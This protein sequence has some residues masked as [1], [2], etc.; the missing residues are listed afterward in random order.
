VIYGPGRQA[1]AHLFLHDVEHAVI[2]ALLEVY[3]LDH[4]FLIAISCVHCC[5][6][7]LIAIINLVTTHLHPSTL[8]E[9]V[10]LRRGGKLWNSSGQH[11]HLL[12]PA[13][14]RPR[15]FRACRFVLYRVRHVLVPSKSLHDLREVAPGRA[16][17]LPP[18]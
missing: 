6:P 15:T 13:K 2:I 7:V 3:D 18:F 16:H 9:H 1:C 11:G 8:S 17:G 12:N 4:H 5:K 10:P 14:S